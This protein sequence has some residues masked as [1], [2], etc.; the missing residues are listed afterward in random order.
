M[1]CLVTS[2]LAR[3]RQFQSFQCTLFLASTLSLLSSLLLHTHDRLNDADY[4]PTACANG[5][6]Y[7]A[8]P[9]QR[10]SPS[11]SCAAVVI[12]ST[13]TALCS[14]RSDAAN[15]L[16]AAHPNNPR[17]RRGHACSA[18]FRMRAQLQHSLRPTST[19]THPL[20]WQLVQ[21]LLLHVNF[22]FFAEHRSTRPMLGS[23]PCHS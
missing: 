15:A 7:A 14:S 22:L 8:K 11:S 5:T 18:R 20:H 3:L 2:T 13:P 4:P 6:T 23:K 19:T 21:D 9:A 17:H 10:N 12:P 1:A 16:A